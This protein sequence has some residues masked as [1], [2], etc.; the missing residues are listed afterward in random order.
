MIEINADGTSNRSTGRRASVDVRGDPV[1]TSIPAPV[2]PSVLTWARISIDLSPVAAAR[3]IGV[4][5]D[6]VLEW[7]AGTSVPSMAQLKK[8]AAVYR[9]AL[10]VF[11][12]AEPPQ[13]FDTLRDFRRLPDAEAGRWSPD[14][15]GEFRRARLQREYRLELAELEDTPVPRQWQILDLPASDEQIGA[16]ARRHLMDQARTSLPRGND[17]YE[18]LGYWVAAIEAAGVLV[19][20]TSGGRVKRTEMRA[21]S[22]Y[23]S[24]LPV[25]VLNGADTPRGR[26]FS[27]LH[28]YAHL[29][30]HTEGLC[31]IVMDQHATTPN[32][33]L[34]ARC[35]AIAAWTLMPRADVLGRP[36]VQARLHARSSW[37]YRALA[38]AAGPFGVSAEALLRHLVTL[39]MTDIVFYRARRT[40]FLEAYEHEEERSSAK[41]NWYRNT[42]R[43]LGKGYVRAIADAHSRR[44][45][46]SNTAATYL[47]VKVAQIARLADT[48]TLREA[49]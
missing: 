49:V 8:A 36:E 14:L 12:L 17:R 41:G 45:I 6:R 9:R 37:D 28:E 32:R 16:V 1:A 23:F 44:V 5:D 7:E 42:V 4:P 29:L 31:D 30:L 18:H 40:E 25:I 24:E 3:K 47:N 34:E 38:S 43:D 20:H 26:L 27:L 13:D 46:D 21:M 10:A 35:N 33:E 39:G 2:E 19:L 11:F 22:L 48:A 15:H